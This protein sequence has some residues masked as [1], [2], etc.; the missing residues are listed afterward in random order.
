MKWMSGGTQSDNATEP[1]AD[2]PRRHRVTGRRRRRRLRRRHG[3][4]L[5]RLQLQRR[6]RLLLLLRAYALQLGGGHLVVGVVADAGLQLRRRC[7]I[8]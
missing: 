1:S 7:D 5:L 4:R 2:R 3:R 8:S 6:L